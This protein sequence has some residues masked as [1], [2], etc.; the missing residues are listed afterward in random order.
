MPT[1]RPVMLDTA[2]HFGCWG[3]LQYSGDTLSVDMHQKMT[4]IVKPQMT[5]AHLAQHRLMVRHD[6]QAV[7]VFKNSLM[8]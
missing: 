1:R 3:L 2:K 5:Y 6:G 4:Q 7:S 8:G